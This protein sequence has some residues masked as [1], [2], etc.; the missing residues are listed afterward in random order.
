M[1]LCEL[2]N[3]LLQFIQNFYANKKTKTIQFRPCYNL[4]TLM[5]MNRKKQINGALQILAFVFL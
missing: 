3:D 2:K 1:P 4:Q 5:K